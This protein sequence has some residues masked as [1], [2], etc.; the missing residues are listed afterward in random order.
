MRQT[1]GEG[2]TGFLSSLDAGRAAEE[3]VDETFV[4]K[5]M[6]EMG[7]IHKFC[8]CNIETPFSREEI[9]EIN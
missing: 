8:D 5:A 2:D 4:R 7:G 1:R 3:L 9:V 6:D